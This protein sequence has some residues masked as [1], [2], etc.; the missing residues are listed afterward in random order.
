MRAYELMVII[1]PSLDDQAIGA[2]V[3][4]GI[5]Q[6]QNAGGRIAGVDRWGR[7]RL[8]YEINRKTEGYYAVLQVVGESSALEGLDRSFH[9]ADEVMRHKIIRLPDDEARRRGLL[10]DG[11]AAGGDEQ[12]E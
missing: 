9:L 12:S 11:Q 2:V 4:N 5:Q 1:D 10:G 6:I 8:A 7:R 3:D